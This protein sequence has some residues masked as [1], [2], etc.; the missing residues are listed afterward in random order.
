MDYKEI[1]L[2]NER[3]THLTKRLNRLSGWQFFKVLYRNDFIKIILL[4]I[5]L[6]LFTVPC[7]L[8]YYINQTN[9]SMIMSLLPY[10]NTFGVGTSVWLGT[11]E[12]MT[13]QSL[14]CNN[15]FHL[16]GSLTLLVLAFIFSG[17][18]AVIRDSFW[19]GKLVIFKPFF[20][21]VAANIPYTLG[22]TAVLSGMY[23]GIYYLQ[24]FLISVLPLW[25]AIVII[26]FA[27][28]LLAFT[29]LYMFVLFS[30]TVTYKQ[31]FAQNLKDS[32][33]LLFMNIFPNIFHFIFALIPFALIP[34]MSAQILSALIVVF[35]LMFGM[36]YLVFV[37][38][39]H[40]M[41]T[42]A[43][44]HPVISKKSEAPK[45]NPQLQSSN[46]NKQKA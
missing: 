36:F 11:S 4:N 9:I 19:T 17:G 24:N 3:S 39:V 31:S 35:F 7:I 34:L 40:M 37:W 43:L 18:F 6:L 45:S 21:G 20:S 44:F 5:F 29:A 15:Q 25:A 8:L 1:L 26:V 30:V 46:N 42:F 14:I 12:Y 32:W 13:A 27:Y 41:K 23:L 38:S 2:D 22:G 10:S 16:W 33:L 28:L